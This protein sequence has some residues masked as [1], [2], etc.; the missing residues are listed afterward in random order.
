MAKNGPVPQN[1]NLRRQ[2]IFRAKNPPSSDNGPAIR[3]AGASGRK[4]PEESLA[5]SD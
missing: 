3:A 1:E 2:K 5:H 4:G